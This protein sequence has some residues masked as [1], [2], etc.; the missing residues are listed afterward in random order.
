MMY[1]KGMTNKLE[2][3]E[4]FVRSL[5][6]L[7]PTSGFRECRAAVL[8]AAIN[9]GMDNSKIEIIK[10]SFN[11]VGVT[12][13]PILRRPDVTHGE[14]GTIAGSVADADD[15]RPVVEA[16]ILADAL[17]GGAYS[18]AS[19]NFKITVTE[20]THDIIVKAQGYKP[21]KRTGITVK[22]GETTYLENTILLED[23]S[24]ASSMAQ[25]G[26]TVTN[27]VSGEPVEGVTLKFRSD[28]DHK[29]GSYEKNTQGEDLVI[30]TDASGKYYTAEL[31]Y[32]YYTA[33]VTKSGYATQYV[34]IIASNNTEVSLHQDIVLAPE[35]SGNVF[36]ITLEWAENPRD[37]DAHIVGDKPGNFHVF[38]KS[39]NAVFDGETIA[40]LDH[41]DRF[42]NGFETVTLK[43]DPQGFY[44][45]YVYHYEGSGCLATS[46]AIV[47]VYQ[48]DVMVNS[49][50]VPVDQGSGRYWNVF[51]IKNGQVVP[52][53]TVTDA[54]E[55]YQDRGNN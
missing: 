20:G 21:C 38:Y 43:V 4:L 41:D 30:S 13:Q 2:L 7:N 18:D 14:T 33:E 42:G 3:A 6:Y 9:M 44:H 40:N 12:V 23:L 10:S 52:I 36:R 19:G 45:Y 48:G 39:K 22:K 47:K 35:A 50:N 11:S 28:W 29:S 26:G 55:S 8:R 5:E 31:Q 51:D 24:G 16:Q 32:G 34:N 53:N 15:R 1:S 46:N 54:R 49:F 17:E 25:A 27:A 37:E